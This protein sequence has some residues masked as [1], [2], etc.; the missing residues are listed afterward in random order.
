MVVDGAGCGPSQKRF[1][2][3]R[4]WNQGKKAVLRLWNVIEWV[5]G[6]LKEKRSE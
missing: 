4:H 2:S 6:C 3:Q 1:R 5:R